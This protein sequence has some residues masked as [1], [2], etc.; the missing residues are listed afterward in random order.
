M[1]TAFTRRAL[2]A[3]GALWLTGCAGRS[4]RSGRAPPPGRVLLFPPHVT[5]GERVLGGRFRL[6]RDWS[7]TVRRPVLEAAALAVARRRRAPVFLEDPRDAGTAW[8]LA[9]LH[10]PVAESL[11]D[12]D[13][14]LT[15]G[16]PPATRR[17]PGL[18]AGGR[19]LAAAYAAPTGLFVSV[20]GGY[21]EGWQR[22]A[23]AVVAEAFNAR[24][25]GVERRVMVSLVELETGQVFWSS[26]RR[27]RSIRDPARAA[28]HVAQMVL[29]A[30][31]RAPERA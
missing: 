29:R 3:G 9:R 6:R 21:A 12:Y 13:A 5:L 15:G 28:R 23:E 24:V 1:T 7:E 11:M 2:V 18:G 30:R 10:R 14:A 25:A 8:S 17:R 26:A 20:T 22:A 4:F 19:A 27:D 16:R 31:F